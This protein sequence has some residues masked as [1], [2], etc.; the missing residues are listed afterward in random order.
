MMNLYWPYESRTLYRVFATK[1]PVTYRGQLI[2]SLRDLEDLQRLLR[3]EEA[4][5]VHQ[6]NRITK[7]RTTGADAYDTRQ[8]FSLPTYGRRQSV[9]VEC[10]MAPNFLRSVFS[11][12][13]ILDTRLTR[14]RPKGVMRLYIR[15][16]KRP[17]ISSP[18][19]MNKSYQPHQMCQIHRRGPNTAVVSESNLHSEHSSIYKL[20]FFQLLHLGWSERVLDWSEQVHGVWLT[21]PSTG[22]T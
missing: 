13:F 8:S 19:H 4:K 15:G 11:P 7:A 22:K 9:N 20:T 12:R 10:M 16:E 17:P 18:N 3:R 14:T 21:V 6:E 2:E 1:L 5:I